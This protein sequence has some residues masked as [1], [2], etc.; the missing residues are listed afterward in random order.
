M[1]SFTGEESGL[2]G[3]EFYAANPLYP[4]EKTVGGFN[5][6]SAAVFGRMNKLGVTGYGH[7]EL[8][9]PVIAAAASSPT[10]WPATTAS[11]GSSPCLRTSS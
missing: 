11:A 5:I 7:S 6:D 3:S 10:E 1:I 9:E 8:D 2:L 4:V